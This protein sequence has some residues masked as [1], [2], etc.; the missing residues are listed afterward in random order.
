MFNMGQARDLTMMKHIARNFLVVRLALV[1]C[2]YHGAEGN[3]GG[4]EL[5]IGEGTIPGGIELEFKDDR[6]RGCHNPHLASRARD[7]LS[8]RQTDELLLP[9]SGSGAFS[10]PNGCGASSLPSV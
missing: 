4:E 8:Y 7:V 6:A 9:R 10:L 2:S 5:L 3:Q 1:P